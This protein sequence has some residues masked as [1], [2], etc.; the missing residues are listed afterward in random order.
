VPWNVEEAMEALLTDPV[1]GEDVGIRWAGSVDPASEDGD[2]P[3]VRDCE[4]T[5][6]LD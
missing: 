5:A 4:P 3:G 2:G 1:I 6:R